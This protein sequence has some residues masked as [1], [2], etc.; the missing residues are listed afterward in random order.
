MSRQCREEKLHLPKFISCISKYKHYTTALSWGCMGLDGKI[1]GD[2]ALSFLQYS[3]IYTNRAI[4]IVTINSIILYV[5]TQES[6]HFKWGFKGSKKVC[7][8]L[9]PSI[10]WLSTVDVHSIQAVEKAI[11]TTH[12]YQMYVTFLQFMLLY[13]FTR[14]QTSPIPLS[15]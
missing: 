7:I 12:L 1:L 11:L 5:P 4:Q 3:T 9:Q 10:Q 8:Q 14:L 13:T 2:Q 6:H 15:L